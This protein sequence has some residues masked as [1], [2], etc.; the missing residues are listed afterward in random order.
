MLAF[1]HYKVSI[2]FAGTSS[3]FQTMNPIAWAQA[4]E[5]SL[6]IYTVVKFVFTV[7]LEL[8]ITSDSEV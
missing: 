8:L 1:V 5:C 7:H 3:V 4:G 6:E 2:R